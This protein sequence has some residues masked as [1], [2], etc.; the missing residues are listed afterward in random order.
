MA[1]PD[2]RT[3]LEQLESAGELLHI[4]NP[5]DPKFQVSAVLAK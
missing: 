2:L 4:D 5:L 3:F 1:N